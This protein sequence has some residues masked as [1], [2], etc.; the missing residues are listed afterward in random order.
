MENYFSSCGFSATTSDFTL[1]GP[2]T[3]RE[4]ILA[5]TLSSMMFRRLRATKSHRRREYCSIKNMEKSEWEKITFQKLQKIENLHSPG[6]TVLN[7]A[8]APYFTVFAAVAVR[9]FTP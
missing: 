3:R 2:E 8:S 7:S 1:R 5:L 6:S 9:F 4:D